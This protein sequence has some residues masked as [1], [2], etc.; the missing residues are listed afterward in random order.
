M[1]DLG[2]E[3]ASAYV[4]IACEGGAED[5]IVRMLLDEGAFCFDKSRLIGVTRLRKAS[6]I[7]RQYLG[8]EYDL[9]VALLY[10]TDSL[11]SRFAL[12]PLYRDTCTV[13][14]ICTRPEIEMLI[15]IN[16]GRYDDF[17]RSRMKPSV[18]CKQKLGMRDVKR[19]E[20][21]RRYWTAAKL[22]AAIAEY[23]RLHH[24]EKGE[25]SFAQIVR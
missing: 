6:D 21:V 2:E 18:Y 7:E 17:V 11:R 10:V 22:R 19:P 13:Y 1:G 23:G 14:R 4:L 20:E 8:Y 24:F 3:L 15:I 16:E 12:S 5:A 9:P 25:L